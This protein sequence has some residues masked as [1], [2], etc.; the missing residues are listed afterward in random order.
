MLQTLVQNFFWNALVAFILTREKKRTHFFNAFVYP[1]PFYE[2]RC[3]SSKSLS[4]KKSTCDFY[5][6]FFLLV[7]FHLYMYAFVRMVEYILHKTEIAI[8]HLMSTSTF[9]SIINA[10]SSRNRSLLHTN[11]KEIVFSSISF[12]VF[13][14]VSSFLLPSKEES[15]HRIAL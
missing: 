4:R 1:H 10:F 14:S 7:S 13:F 2:M 5:Y 15:V 11:F 8:F 3:T 6:F 12:R 9:K